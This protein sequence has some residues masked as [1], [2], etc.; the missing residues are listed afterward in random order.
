MEV[1]IGMNTF[2]INNIKNRKVS[3]KNI[4]LVFLVFILSACG[5]VQFVSPYDEMIDNGIK[6]YKESINTLAK[7]LSDKAGEKE[8][9]Y[10]E[11]Q[12]KYNALEAKIDLL[13]DRASLQASGKGCKLATNIA[14]RVSEIM[15]DKLPPEAQQKD[16]GDSY[17]CTEKLLILV[18][19]Q[20]F[21][22]QKIHENTG[23]CTAIG[24]TQDE[25]GQPDKVSCLRPATSSTAMKIT[26][27]SV[28]AVWVVETAKKLKVRN[29]NGYQY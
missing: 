2:E 14:D 20:L 24:I 11:N 29:K 19:E 16:P 18:K 25:N 27:Q 26:N 10:E 5:T 4:G 28:N 15:G 3:M 8:G 22:L 1:N 13:I 21:L 23:K 12:T 17:G 9:T 7:N 6:E